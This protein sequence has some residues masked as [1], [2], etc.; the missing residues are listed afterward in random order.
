MMLM[1]ILVLAIMF[2]GRSDDN[3]INSN[4]DVYIDCD[5]IDHYDDAD[6]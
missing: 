6:S 2:S 3:D 4:S 1:M 5:S